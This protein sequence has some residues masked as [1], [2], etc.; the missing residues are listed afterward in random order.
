MVPGRF[1]DYISTPK[2]N[3]YRSLHTTV[4]HNNNAARR[5]PDPQPGRC[6]RRPS[7]AWPR[8]GPT[9]RAAIRCRRARGRPLDL[10]PGRNPRP[11][12]QPGRA[13]RAYPHGDVS[14]QDLRLHPKGELIQLPKG[15]TPVDF[16]YALHTRP[17]RP[18]GG[19]EGQRPRRAAADPD[20]RQRRSGRRSSKSAAQQ[21]QPGWLQLRRHR[22]GARG[23]PPLRPPQ[24][25]GRDRWRS[26]A[27]SST[28][29]S[30]RLPAPLGPRRLNQALKR[31]LPRRDGADDRH[32][33]AR[34]IDDAEVM[35][36]LMPGS[37]ARAR[38]AA[39]ARPAAAHS[40]SIR[41]LTPG[42]AFHLAD[43]LPPCRGTV[44]SGLR[45]GAR[46]WTCTPSAAPRSPARPISTGST[47]PGATRRRAP[48]PSSP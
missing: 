17:G 20:P 5:G 39:P 31:L 11:C 21:P 9:S 47:C 34:P 8:T 44:S 6:M 19:R 26:A 29:S 38:R 22:Q 35:E 27:N 25:A 10:R 23:D 24:G 42:V 37:G 2:R 3:G 14:G 43:L 46:A 32:R 33:R 30:A 4:I 36:A 7:A 13:A 16:A 28:R 18:D 41:G 12:R 15:A 1:K 40:I 48:S 45:R